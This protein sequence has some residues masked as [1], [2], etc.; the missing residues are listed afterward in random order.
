MHTKTRVTYVELSLLITHKEPPTPRA[1][2]FCLLS[3]PAEAGL[4]LDWGISG[5][6][7]QVFY[8]T[9]ACCE[10]VPRLS[11]PQR[12]HSDKE[13]QLASLSMLMLSSV[14]SYLYRHEYK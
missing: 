2:P 13:L 3:A 6:E 14:C 7:S 5:G 8:W 1:T 9:W 11:A 12:K 4:G 10:R